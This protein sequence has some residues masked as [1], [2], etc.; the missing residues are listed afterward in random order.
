MDR[1]LRAGGYEPIGCPSGTAAHDV[2]LKAQPSAVIV[3]TW[4]ETRESGW[5]LLQ[6]LIL[7]DATRHI[8]IVLCSSDV[9]GV[10][11][12]IEELDKVSHLVV[13]P[14]PFDPEAL[15]K[16]LQQALAQPPASRDGSPAD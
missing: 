13:L 10:A 14:K 4:L 2:I 8:P 5:Q 7:D 9:D 12:R 16:K 1:I 11:R 6:T 3:D 15:L